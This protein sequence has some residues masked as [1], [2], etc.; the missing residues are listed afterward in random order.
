MLLKQEFLHHM[1]QRQNSFISLDNLKTTVKNY[2]EQNKAQG[3]IQALLAT[4]VVS[5]TP[6]IEVSKQGLVTG[7][8]QEEIL[9]QSEMQTLETKFKEFDDYCK[10]KKDVTITDAFI[11]HVQPLD[12]TQ[13]KATDREVNLLKTISTKLANED[14]EIIGYG[15]DRDTTYSALHKI[16]FDS[17]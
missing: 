13:G 16:Y 1:L 3:K 6:E 14:I 2:R 8:L 7:L 10:I 15:F 11:F 9:K 12:A 5:L 17:C 4:D